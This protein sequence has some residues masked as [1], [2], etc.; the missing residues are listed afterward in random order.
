MNFEN[1]RVLIVGVGKSGQSAMKL[2]KEKGCEIAVYDDKIKRTRKNLNGKFDMAILSPGISDGCA[3][4]KYINENSIP[5]ITEIELGLL[6]LKSKNIIAVTGTNGKTTCVSLLEHIFNKS[7]RRAISC[8]NN[9]VPL[10]SV[11]E[12]IERKDFVILE[13]SSFMLEKINKA[14]VAACK[15][16][17]DGN[18]EVIVSIDEEKNLFRVELLKTVVKKII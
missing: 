6:F 7:G 2:L 12:K 8:G 10:T 18:E 15:N 1:K 11:C 4:V 17:Y 9:G 3:A 5:A 16:N 14:I 13:L